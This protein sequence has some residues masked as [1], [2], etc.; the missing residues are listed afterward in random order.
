MIDRVLGARFPI[1]VTFVCILAFSVYGAFFLSIDPNN[2]VFYSE[3]HEHFANLLDLEAKFGSNT[4]LLFLIVSEAPLSE[5]KTL[6]P[7]IRWLTDAAWRIERVVAVDSIATFPHV[8]GDQDELLVDTLLNFVCPEDAVCIQKRMSALREPHLVD[9]LFSSEGTAF[10]VVAKVDLYAPSSNDV[11]VIAREAEELKQEFRSRHPSL[12]LYLTGGVPMMQAFFDAAQQDSESLL[13]IALVIL[14]VALYVFLGGVLPTLLIMLLGVSSVAVTMGVAGWLGFV[15]NTATATVPLIVLTLVVT[16]AMHFFLHVVR[17][18]GM[19]TNEGV[20]RAVKIGVAANW[21]PILLTAATTVAGLLSMV[22]VS[23]PPVKELGLLASLGMSV[24]T[25]F[26]LTVIPCLFTYFPRVRASNWLS[27]LQS[28][29][30]RYAKW[31]ERSRPNMVGVALIFLAGLTGLT[32]VSMDEDFVRYFA[33]ET[34]F[35]QDTEAIT[36]HLASPYHIDVVYD[37]GQSAGVYA[38]ESIL[39]IQKLIDFVRQDAR[40]V[41][42]TSIIDVF[43]EISLV[44]SGSGNLLGRTPNEL[45]QY[46]LTYELSLNVGQSAGD[47]LDSDHRLARVSILMS[48]VSM[49]E[50]RDFNDDVKEWAAVS[51]LSDQVTVTGEGIPTAYLSSESIKQMSVGILTSIALSAFMVGLYFRSLATGIGI[52][53]AMVIPILVGFGFWSWI[54]PEFGMAATLVVAITIGVIIDDTIHLTYRYVDSSRNLDLT[55]WGATA[56]SIHKAGT[57]VV[58]TSV[59]LAAGLLTL[60]GSQ[61]RMNSTF[62][63][64]SSIVIAVALIYN[65]TIAPYFLRRLRLETTSSPRSQMWEQA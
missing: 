46:F 29:M 35:R 28:V 44:M 40:V 37:S 65:L 12:S 2:R 32:N 34:T 56:Y 25:L 14:A 23:S 39:D 48:D 51:G 49:A 57:A 24:G 5:N 1:V 52:F 20:V 47:L 19:G 18:E 64:C 8:T 22:T 27:A 53:L 62:G 11:T 26:T 3:R 9:R 63:V 15:I 45:A 4:N 31:L 58:V 36:Q 7:A 30:N 10:A 38:E 6:A 43:E 13:A 41:N 55:P 50:I 60:M 59:V 21:R 17:E 54:D 33:P 42:A 61:F 16:G